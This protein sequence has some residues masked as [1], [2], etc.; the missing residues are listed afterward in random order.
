M[1]DFWEQFEIVGYDKPQYSGT[2]LNAITI[3]I[4]IVLFVIVLF[5]LFKFKNKLID[6]IQKNTK[7]ILITII[8]TAVLVVVYNLFFRYEYKVVKEGRKV[9]KIDKLTG[10]TTYSHPEKEDE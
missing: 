5:L 7:N 10:K 3:T 9:I 2:E 6:F 8:G 4:I 1:T